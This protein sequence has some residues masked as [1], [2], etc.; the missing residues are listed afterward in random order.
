MVLFFKAS[1][2]TAYGS[3]PID[4]ASAFNFSSLDMMPRTLFNPF[5]N[6]F[7]KL[8]SF[9]S[10][11]SADF[12]ILKCAFGFAPC[13]TRST[14]VSFMFLSFVANIYHLLLPFSGMKKGSLFKLLIVVSILFSLPR[15]QDNQVLFLAHHPERLSTSSVS[16]RIHIWLRP[17]LRSQLQ[18]CLRLLPDLPQISKHSRMS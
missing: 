13:L 8:M 12:N 1:S 4:F 10:P 9:V 5:L 3:W 14:L 15:Q 11:P 18:W 16:L 17:S 2:M 7:M 6:V